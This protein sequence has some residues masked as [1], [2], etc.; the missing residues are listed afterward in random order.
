MK[1]LILKNFQS[2]GDIVMLTAAIRDLHLNYPD[3]FLTD[4]RTSVPDL[5]ENNPYL[6]PLKEEDPDVQVMK[7]E[8]PLIHKSN[9]TPY[10]FIF[11]FMEHLNEKL[12]LSIKPTLFKGDIHL[13][14]EEKSWM[15]QVQ[16]ITG[17][18]TKYWIIDA[19]GKYDFTA[20]WWAPDR[21]QD[22]VN[23]FRGK[24]QF[25]QIGSPEH[26]HP[27]LEGVI[28]LIGKTSM[29]QLIRLFFHADGVLTPVSLPMHLAAAVDVRP[30][31]PK[32]RPCVVVAGGREPVQWEAY[33]HHQFIHTNGALYCCDQGGCWASR[34]KPLNDGSEQDK[35]L[36]VNV[37]K[38]LPRCM[39]MISAEEVIRRIEVYYKGGTLQ[40]PIA[41]RKSTGKTTVQPVGQRRV[42]RVRKL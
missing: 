13:T 31:M 11:G 10:H 22:V 42:K 18:P 12:N 24:I 39:D 21:Y 23:Y 8:Y 26:Y 32:N 4:V 15:P 5:W 38:D 30:G 27:P 2:P 40:Y 35:S 34:V 29:R 41:E 25:V 1:K 19:G 20:K 9:T 14:Q 37:V 28:N 7:A 17:K 16:E 3:Q 33:P 36:C 6:T